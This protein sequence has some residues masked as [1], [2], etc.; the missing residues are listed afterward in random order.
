MKELNLGVLAK[1]IKEGE[2]MEEVVQEIDQLKGDDMIESLLIVNKIYEKCPNVAKYMEQ[3][4]PSIKMI[5]IMI[6]LV[7]QVAKEKGISFEEE[8][9]T[10]YNEFKDLKNKKQQVDETATVENFKKEENIEQIKE[11]I[12]LEEKVANLPDGCRFL[13]AYVHDENIFDRCFVS[14]KPQEDG[15][16]YIYPNN[17]LDMEKDIEKEKGYKNVRILNI[18][19]LD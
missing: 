19:E 2:Q 8:L 9:R 6:D 4:M 1:L 16:I 7:K 17:I 13:I 11:P 12:P 10:S 14:I 18:Q 15:E 5:K 3:E